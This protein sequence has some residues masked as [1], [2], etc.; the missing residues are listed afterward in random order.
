MALHSIGTERGLYVIKEG[1]G[2]T[3]LGFAVA[4]RQAT[5]VAKWAGLPAPQEKPGTVA[6]YAEYEKI[7]NAGRAIC[8]LTGTRCP[9]ELTYELIGL[10]GRRVEVVDRDGEKRR[11]IVGKS[12]GWLPVHLEIKRRDSHGGCAVMGAP[13]KSVRI[14]G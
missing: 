13:F 5:A 4:L 9:A 8:Q 1:S 14:V 3:C 2:Y 12:S 7:M 10:E 6:A 11:F